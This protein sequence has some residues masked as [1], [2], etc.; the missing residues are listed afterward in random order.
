MGRPTPVCVALVRHRIE[1]A[2]P[3]DNDQIGQFLPNA[4]DDLA[5]QPGPACK[6]SAVTAG[7]GMRLGTR[8]RDNHGTP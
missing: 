5:Q 2:Q 8:A 4:R 7:P 1:R 3:Y 6:F